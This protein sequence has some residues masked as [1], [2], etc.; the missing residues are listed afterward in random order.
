MH[1]HFLDPYH[2]GA[3]VLHQAD[4]R[5]K[6]VLTLAFILSVS[7]TPIGAW[8]I[9]VLFLTLA[10]AAA[11][12]SELGVAFAM[13]RGLVAVPFAL[14]AV[15]LLFTAK[16]PPLF[17]LAVGPWTVV[18]TTTGAERLLSIVF[19]SWVSVQ[20][21]ILLVATTDFPDLLAAMRAL[22]I[23]RLLVAIVALMWRYLAVLADEAGRLNRAR[24]ARSGSLS[25]RGGGSLVWRAQVTGYMVGNLFVRGYE[26]GERIYAAMLARG[27]DGEMRSLPRPPLALV[28]WLTVGLGLA[29]LSSLV[30][31]GYLV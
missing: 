5:V 17:D 9:Y 15:P 10:V 30:I 19:K 4:P 24:A 11:V 2:R 28:H 12:A 14:A 13:R 18:V 22:R 8:P 7:A 31:L 26:R 25:G 29:L 21:A 3:S 23:P 27:Y 20:A 1:F 6:L 16:G